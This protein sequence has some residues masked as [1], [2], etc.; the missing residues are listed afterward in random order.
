VT[1]AP[2]RKKPDVLPSPVV[3]HWP[4]RRCKRPCGVTVETQHARVTANEILRARRERELGKHEVMLCDGCRA[5][6]DGLDRMCV[7]AKRPHQQLGMQLEPPP[8]SGMQAKKPTTKRRS[9]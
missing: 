7:E 3:D 8:S 1:L 6:L 5:E 4:C 2:G 9:K